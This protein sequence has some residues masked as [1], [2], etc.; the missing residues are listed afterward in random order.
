M[1]D[2]VLVQ[3]EPDQAQTIQT[4]E[5]GLVLSSLWASPMSRDSLRL[6]DRRDE[7]ESPA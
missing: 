2:L 5:V 3:P 1:M 7:G 4:I 6:S